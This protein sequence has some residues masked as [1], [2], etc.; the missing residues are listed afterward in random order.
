MI[1]TELLAQILAI[2]RKWFSYFNFWLKIKLI[3]PNRQAQNS[4][5]NRKQILTSTS[6]GKIR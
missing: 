5:T 6:D 4:D 3:K 1:A 2:N